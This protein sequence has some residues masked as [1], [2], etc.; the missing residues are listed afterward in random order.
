MKHFL[1]WTRPN[2]VRKWNIQIERHLFKIYWNLSRLHKHA[3]F[4][5]KQVKGKCALLMNKKLLWS[6]EIIIKKVIMNKS[7][8]RNSTLNHYDYT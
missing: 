2:T 5:S 4:K 7:R 3:P 8:M 1:S 6:Y